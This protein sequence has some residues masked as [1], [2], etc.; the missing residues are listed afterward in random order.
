VSAFFT[1]WFFV[2]PPS[3]SVGECAAR[4]VAWPLPDFL[5]AAGDGMRDPVWFKV[6]FFVAGG[7]I[8]HRFL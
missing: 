4:K 6:D 2:L 1:I 3:F 8:A 7:L 5:F